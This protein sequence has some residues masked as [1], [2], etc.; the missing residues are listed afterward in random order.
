M[1]K[2]RRGFVVAVATAAIVTAANASRGA[3]FSQSWGWVALAFLVPTTLVLILDPTRGPGRLRIAF[4]GFMCTLTTWTL[5]SS[6]WSISPS[7]SIREFERALVYVAVALAVAIVLRR[8]DG[9]AVIAGVLTGAS[10]ISGYALATRLLPDRFDTVADPLLQN[11]LSDPLGYPNALGLLATMGLLLA[12]GFVSHSRNVGSVVAAGSVMPLFAATLYFTFSRGAWAALVLAFCTCVAFDRRRIRLV[13][14]ATVTVLP[15]IA[16]VAFLSRQDALTTTDMTS[17]P[18]G[19][20]HRAGLA[21]VAVAACSA[22]LAWIAHSTAR[23]VRLSRSANRT[24]GVVFVGAIAAC[25]LVA[26]VALGGPAQGLSEVKERF[27][28]RQTFTTDLN[29]R[30]VSLSGTGRTDIWPVAWHQFKA[31]PVVGRGAGSFEYVWY[32]HRSSDRIVRDAHSLYLETLAELGIVGLLLLCAALATIVSGFFAAR[33]SRYTAAAAGAFVAWAITSVLDWHWEM[34]GVTMTALLVG[35]VGLLAAERGRSGGLASRA[36]LVLLVVGV[37][38]SVMSVVSLVGNQALFAGR[39]ALARKDWGS[40]RFHSDRARQLLPWSHEP[41]LA[42][43]DAEAGLGDRE[44]A[45]EAYRDAVATDPRNWA[46]W[47]RLAQVAS[48]AERSAAY[49]KVHTLNPRQK[50]LPGETASG[51]S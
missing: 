44:A 45:L 24:A 48:G 12:L 19:A 35:S 13:W 28:V 43:G 51:P 27:Y 15:S 21:L 7:G 23:R 33:R 47:L 32:E 9:P 17:A 30:V 11:R 37:T 20:G 31:T 46:A 50:R 10:L 39:N 14:A 16:Y 3:Y 4:A 6:F 41:N 8:G 26:T 38:L 40:A 49:A 22:I 36:R 25:V 5:L 2:R 1:T 18:S 34:V 29:A 42:L